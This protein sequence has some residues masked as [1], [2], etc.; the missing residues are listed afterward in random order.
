MMRR[1][2]DFDTMYEAMVRKDETFE[3]IFIVGVKTTGIFCRPGCTARTPKKMN[4]EFF[5]TPQEALQHGYR[6][7]KICRP[8]AYKGAIPDWLQPLISEVNETPGIS[9]KDIDIRERGVDPNRVRR[10]FQK[11]HGMTFQCYLRTLRM[12]QA[13]GRIRHGEMVS[14]AAFES[15]YDSLSGFTESFKNSTGF[16]P[17]QSPHNNLIT[18]TRILTPLGPMLAGATE[19]GICLLE[20]IDR[21]MLETQL[22]RLNSR[23]QSICVPGSHTHFEML[24]RQLGEYFAGTRRE[25]DLPLVMPGTPFQESVWQGLREIPYGTTRSYQQQAEHLGNPAATRAVARANGDNRIG[26]I[27]PCHRVIGKNGKLVGYG[28]GLWRKR[29][30]LDHEIKFSRK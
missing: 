3:G 14:E 5:R 22:K 19:Q 12:G 27:I 21:R 11:H 16:S 7:C 2:P 13:F 29:Y 23:L 24:S 26:I 25:F 1:L 18:V 15:G 20:F 6:P 9:L 10:W 28:G 8:M 4:V 30:L 17:N